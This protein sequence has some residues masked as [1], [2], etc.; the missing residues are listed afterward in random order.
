MLHN[1]QSFSPATRESACIAGG[2]P[3]S[4]FMFTG[5]YSIDL[6]SFLIFS[7]DLG[8]GFSSASTLLASSFESDVS[9]LC[10]TSR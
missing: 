10:L 8:K 3:S 7:C 1:L 5:F 9:L 6:C 2:F 4:L